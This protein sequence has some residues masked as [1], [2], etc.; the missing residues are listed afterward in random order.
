MS[1]AVTFDYQNLS[2]NVSTLAEVTNIVYNPVNGTCS[3]TVFNFTS[4]QLSAADPNAD[5]L[6]HKIRGQ[7]VTLSV[8]PETGR[9]KYT[10]N[11]PSEDFSRWDG[12][13]TFTCDGKLSGEIWDAVPNTAGYDPKNITACD[14]VLSGLPR[15]DIGLIRHILSNYSDGN[16][17][18]K[19]Q[20]TLKYEAERIPDEN[21]N[22][23]KIISCAEII[24][25]TGDEDLKSLRDAF[26]GHIM[27]FSEDPTNPGNTIVTAHAETEDGGLEQQPQ[28]FALSS[29]M[30]KKVPFNLHHLERSATVVIRV[31]S[32][33]TSSAA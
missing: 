9:S 20:V 21:G 25:R 24:P 16:S 14:T 33:A 28:H 17:Y 3:F 30:A 18:R 6:F 7:I 32:A 13:C 4:R 29:T 1:Q 5:D 31:P 26:E 22:S 10:V 15:S 8:D 27:R 2:Q 11:I 19:I 12:Q 23:H